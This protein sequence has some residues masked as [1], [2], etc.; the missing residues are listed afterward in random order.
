MQ[1][2]KDTKSKNKSDMEC[3]KKRNEVQKQRD[4]RNK[5]EKGRMKWK[6]EKK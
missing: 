1:E 4:E 2:A 6:N 3:R 5:R